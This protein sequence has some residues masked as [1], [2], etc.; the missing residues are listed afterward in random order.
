MNYDIYIDLDQL[1]STTDGNGA[2]TSYKYDADGD[3][4]TE[5][6]H[7]GQ[8]NDNTYNDLDQLVHTTDANGDTTRYTYDAAGNQLSS[9]DALDN[10]TSYAY[11]SFGNQVSETDPDGNKTS[12]SYDLGRK[13]DGRDGDCPGGAVIGTISW[14]YDPTATARSI[15]TPTTGRR[16]TDTTSMTSLPGRTGQHNARRAAS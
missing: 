12:Y 5:T 4:L 2:T 16:P 9:T 1:V 10:T 7:A 6:D 8:R 15:P 14:Q 3:Q 11:N 13:Q